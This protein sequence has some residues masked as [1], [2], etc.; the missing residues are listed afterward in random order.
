MTPQ[1]WQSA[2]ALSGP[3]R[4]QYYSKVTVAL[5]RG[6]DN[7]IYQFDVAIPVG[8]EQISGLIAGFTYE[9]KLL[10]AQHR[11]ST[12]QFGVTAALAN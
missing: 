3:H 11:E 12:L 7:Y 6:E 4:G 10:R 8:W 1:V 2:M 5:R 9:G